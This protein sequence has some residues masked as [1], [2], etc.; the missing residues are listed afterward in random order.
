MSWRLDKTIER[1]GFTF[2][3]WTSPAAL[4][5]AALDSDFD[6]HPTIPGQL[7]VEDALADAAL[8]AQG[9]RCRDGRPDSSNE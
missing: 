5:F 2:E 8:P 1:E 6:G 4:H 7:T 9:D 3:F